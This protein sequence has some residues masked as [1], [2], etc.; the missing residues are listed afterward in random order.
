MKTALRFILAI[1]AGLFVLFVLLVAVELFSAVVHPVPADFGHTEKEVIEHVARYPTWVLAV[2]APM[3]AAAAF[4]SVWTARHIGNIYA[5]AIVGLLLLAALVCNL[6]MLPYPLWF[7]AVCLLLIP[8]AV[9]AG[10][11]LGKSTVAANTAN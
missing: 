3:W 6:S 2:A 1:I 10:S 5:A 11:R 9:L 7:K 4:A 8:L